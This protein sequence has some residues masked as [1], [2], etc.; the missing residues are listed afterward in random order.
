MIVNER[1]VVLIIYLLCIFKLI[2]AV[3][4][5]NTLF[6]FDYHKNQT[7]ANNFTIKVELKE[8]IKLKTLCNTKNAC[9]LKIAL[10]IK[11]N[12]NLSFDIWCNAPSVF[13]DL[14]K[15]NHVRACII[16]IKNV[17]TDPMIIVTIRA[18]DNGILTPILFAN[19]SNN[20]RHDVDEIVGDDIYIYPPAEHRLAPRSNIEADFSKPDF[21]EQLLV[22]NVA[23]SNRIGPLAEVIVSDV[24]TDVLDPVNNIHAT[25]QA[26]V[27]QTDALQS[28]LESNDNVASNTAKTTTTADLSATSDPSVITST[29]ESEGEAYS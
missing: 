24:Q 1:I 20:I 17:K 27:S 19:F 15:N 8:K 26:A 10:K 16:D 14:D 5:L 18:H 13:I 12:K 28:D 7:T 4:N 29:D 6:L 22:D 11:N 23:E 25:T 2:L 3:S 9:L 21:E